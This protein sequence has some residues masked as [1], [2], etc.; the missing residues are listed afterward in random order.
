MKIRTFFTICAASLIAVSTFS[1][2]KGDWAVK[3]DDDVITIDEF[4]KYYYA[5]NKIMLN[6]SKDEIDKLITDP[7]L[8]DV[9]KEHPTLNKTSFMDFL[10]S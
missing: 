2:G 3:I 5:Q 4:Y 7:A 8:K 1:C 6:K 10:V 9:I